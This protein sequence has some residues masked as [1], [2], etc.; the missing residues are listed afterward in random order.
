MSQRRPGSA[1]RSRPGSA[2]GVASLRVGEEGGG[3]PEGQLG[4]AGRAGTD[5]LRRA[6]LEVLEQRPADPIRFLAQHFKQLDEGAGS[7]ERAE[8]HVWLCPQDHGADAQNVADASQ[9]LRGEEDGPGGLVS[10]AQYE[11]L[12]AALTKKWPA[13]QRSRFLNCLKIEAREGVAFEL[14]RKAVDVVHTVET[15]LQAFPGGREGLESPEARMSLIRRVLEKGEMPLEA[16]A[17]IAVR[18]RDPQ[19]EEWGSWDLMDGL[20][21]CHLQSPKNPA[22]G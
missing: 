18:F 2:T 14:F 7:L 17:Q 13:D 5:A 20:L 3:R 4:G 19:R 11:Q 1:G 15:I 6:L 21:D 9:A 8:R 22:G 16:D 12:L 10:C